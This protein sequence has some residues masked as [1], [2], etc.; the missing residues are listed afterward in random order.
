MRSTTF[1][2][3]V[4]I[5]ATSGWG[6]Q[7]YS[8]TGAADYSSG[9]A[10]GIPRGSIF[11]IGF[12]L[13]GASLMGVPASAFSAPLPV[14]FHGVSVGIWTAPGGSGTLLGQAPLLYVSPSQINAVLPSSIPAGSYSIGVEGATLVAGYP[15][16]TIWASITVI[17]GRFAA[18]TRTSRGFGPAAALQYDPA[19]NVS[20]NGLA[21][22]A[23]PGDVISLWGTGLGALPS[24]SD[25]G[26]PQAANL[27]GDVTV[28]VAGIPVTPTYAGRAPGLPGVDQINFPLP[29]GVAPR[30]FVPV[31]IQTGSARSSVVRLAVS[32]DGSACGNDLTLP[33]TMLRSLD[34]G[35]PLRAV[36]LSF[37]STTASPSGSATQTALTLSGTWDE[38]DLSLLSGPGT[39]LPLPQCTR[40]DQVGSVI[41]VLRA[42]FPA[43]NIAGTGGCQWAS[44]SVG[45]AASGFS[46]GPELGGI[47]GSLPPPLPAGEIGSL[48]AS[49][50]GQS[51]TASWSATPGP[52]DSVTV[53]AGSSYTAPGIFGAD[54]GKTY[55]NSLSCVVDPGASPFAFPAADAAWALQYGSD[56]VSLTLT[57]VTNQVFPLSGGGYDFL[58]VNVVNSVGANYQGVF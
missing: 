43:P 47:S 33:R 50:A 11:T 20:I 6:Q 35:S 2:L 28:Y 46:F 18:F 55:S 15:A 5:W 31:A 56:T 21:T 25:T 19:G 23:V 42:G 1:G 44:G 57:R 7:P 17:D 45:C 58:V 4:L 37:A 51:L 36:V 49:S 27:R 29:A 14:T 34:G 30:C 12:P 10:V 38:S 40:S 3:A 32:A 54:P 24:G 22:P 53:Q 13:P 26:A 48:S 16:V 8:V 52:G 41:A 39:A 9:T